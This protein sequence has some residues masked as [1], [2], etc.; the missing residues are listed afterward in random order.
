MI[1]QLAKSL[2][3]MGARHTARKAAYPHFRNPMMEGMGNLRWNQA[4]FATGSGKQ[5]PITPWSSYIKRNNQVRAV[6]K[7]RGR[8]EAGA[9]PKWTL[10]RKR[11]PFPGERSPEMHD[12][13][14]RELQRTGKASAMPDMRMQRPLF[15]RGVTE[16][17]LADAAR[18]HNTMNNPMVTGLGHGGF[19]DS[20]T[21]FNPYQA[22]EM[23]IGSRAVSPNVGQALPSLKQYAPP[24]FEPV[25]GWMQ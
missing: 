6:P 12:V 8:L 19:M 17:S 4:D 1:S 18:K 11:E 7:P 25:P 5:V 2:L 9:P 10:Q 16:N 22:S 13:F 23:M 20:T 15:K 24:Q 14:V 3:S 21:W